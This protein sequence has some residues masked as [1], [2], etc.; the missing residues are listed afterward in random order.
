MSRRDLRKWDLTLL[1]QG[2]IVGVFIMAVIFGPEIRGSIIYPSS[3]GGRTSKVGGAVAVADR[4]LK[5]EM[6]NKEHTRLAEQ[7]SNQSE[8]MNGLQQ[9]QAQLIV[10]VKVLSEV[11]G[12]MAER[13]FARLEAGTN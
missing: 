6:Q 8:V 11:V 2:I 7:L 1:K 5:L 9:T 4:V 12:A 13:E 3:A 10:Q